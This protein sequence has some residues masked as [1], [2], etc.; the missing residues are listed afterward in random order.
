MLAALKAWNLR[1]LAVPSLINFALYFVVVLEI[2]P[3]LTGTL[4][5]GLLFNV[6]ARS[7]FFGNSIYLS[8]TR[9]NDSRVA[10]AVIR[11][12]IFFVNLYR[13][14]RSPHPAFASCP[15][16]K[17]VNFSYSDYI[18]SF[19]SVRLIEDIVRLGNNMGEAARNGVL[20]IA[21]PSADEEYGASYHCIHILLDHI[22]FNQLIPSRIYSFN[23]IRMLCSSSGSI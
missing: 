9:G 16:C 6:V 5:E 19:L 1:V 3:L 11:N 8:F 20:K 7:K 14:Q 23:F 21:S 18:Y 17:D 13:F 22:F 2:R 12:I 10:V 15:V 4:Q